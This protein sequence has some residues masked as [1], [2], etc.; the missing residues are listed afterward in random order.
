[1]NAP[2]ILEIKSYLTSRGLSAHS[3]SSV[4][5]TEI[6][7][8]KGDYLTQLKNEKKTT[9]K[10][11]K[12]HDSPKKRQPSLEHGKSFFAQFYEETDKKIEFQE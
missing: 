5:S 9:L 11:K 10:S 7:F 3:D 8:S 6:D 4:S 2:E 12:Y 1:M